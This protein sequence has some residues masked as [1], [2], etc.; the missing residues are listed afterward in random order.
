[1]CTGRD[2]KKY[3]SNLVSVAG[4]SLTVSRNGRGVKV[5]KR[6]KNKGGKWKKRGMGTE[7]SDSKDRVYISGLKQLFLSA[8]VEKQQM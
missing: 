2:E 3:L 6:E 8:C 4:T 5:M 7:T 1:M